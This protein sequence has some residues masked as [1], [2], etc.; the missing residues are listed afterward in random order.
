[1]SCI[2]LGQHDAVL[3]IRVGTGHMSVPGWIPRSRQVHVGIAWPVSRSLSRSQRHSCAGT[4]AGTCN[5]SLAGPS[6]II[7]SKWKKRSASASVVEANVWRTLG[8][9]KQR[10]AHTLCRPRLLR[11]SSSS[12]IALSGTARRHLRSLTRQS[13]TAFLKKNSSAS[14]RNNLGTRHD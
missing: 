12:H 13:R 14:T 11:S 6:C 7:V 8:V 3:A 9:E 1:M 2:P 5:V 10:G 4:C